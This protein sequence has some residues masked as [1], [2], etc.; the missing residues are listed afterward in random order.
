MPRT[1]DWHSGRKIYLNGTLVLYWWDING[2]NIYVLASTIGAGR[3]ILNLRIPD[4]SWQ[5]RE[6]KLLEE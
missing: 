5:D 3:T 1:M 2:E 6:P 4:Y